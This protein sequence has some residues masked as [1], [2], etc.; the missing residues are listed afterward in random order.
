MQYIHGEE[1]KSKGS[2]NVSPKS[3]GAS[4][5]YKKKFTQKLPSMRNLLL[6]NDSYSSIQKPLGPEYYKKEFGVGA[7]D[8]LPA[9]WKVGVRSDER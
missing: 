8:V 4:G 9:A 6:T 7:L 3:D 5:K 1:Y 2:G